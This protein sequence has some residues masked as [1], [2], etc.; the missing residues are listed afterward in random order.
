MKIAIFGAGIAGLSAA[1]LLKRQGHS[2][3]VYERSSEMNDRGNAFL[4]HDEGLDLLRNLGNQ[5]VFELMGEP[6]QYF[7][8]FSQKNEEVK[9]IRLMPWTC[10]KRDEV[11]RYLYDTLGEESIV[12]GYEFES[13]HLKGQKFTKAIFTNGEMVEADIFVGADGLHSKVRK[14]LFGST[15]FSPIDTFELLGFVRDSK[16]YSQLKRLFKKF[17]HRSKS[18]A[19]GVLPASDGEL[20]TVLQFDPKIIQ[21]AGILEENHKAMAEYLLADFP[22]YVKEVIAKQ[23]Y[24]ETYIWK[25]RDFD[26]LPQFHKANAVLIGDA[27]HV[28]LPFSSSGTTNA[29]LD[30]QVLAEH[31]KEISQEKPDLSEFDAVF[32]KFYIKRAEEVSQQILFGRQLKDQ[33]LKPEYNP[34]ELQ[35]IPLVNR[36]NTKKPRPPKEK[37]V[38]IIYFTDPICSTCWAIQPELRKLELEYG[39]QLEIEYRMGGLLPH[40]HN[41]NRHGITD[42][43]QVAVHWEEVEAK[44]G[45]PINGEIW[46]TDPLASSYPPSI[47]FKA[48]Q[49]QSAEKA[50]I[51]LRKIREALFVAQ[52]DIIDKGLLYRMA[53]SSA[54]DA[55]QIIKDIEG[56]ATDNFFE[57]VALSEE[58]DIQFLPTLIMTN[59]LGESQR[60][61]GENDYATFQKTINELNPNLNRMTYSKDIRD[62]FS[63]FPSMSLREYVYLSETPLE[64]AKQELDRM[65]RSGELTTWETGKVKLF[66]ST[67]KL[68]QGFV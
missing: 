39:N 14:G 56:P 38:Q 43:K 36:K 20:I 68:E 28:A 22:E 48:A 45:M 2:V 37:R 62:L 65:C 60:I 24:E 34:L 52:R 19:F 40:W 11:I 64:K 47:A 6:I 16:K 46:K 42:P 49:L 5:E 7:Q 25:T 26:L 32:Q 57:D 41:Y 21:E 66:L 35:R 13:F 54:L 8:M 27:A 59:H 9:S 67:V 31:L 63:R 17:Q 51:F 29:I 1:I 55:A 4:M 58:L 30:A 44:S 50:I 33:F 53:L 18:I 3:K 12:H 61:I 10:F 15:Q 23:T